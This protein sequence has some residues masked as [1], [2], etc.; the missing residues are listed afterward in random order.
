MAADAK[1]LLFDEPTSGLDFAHM[2]KVGALLKQL[3]TMGRTVLV[4]TH[5]PELIE[6][7]CDYLLCIKNG[8]VK[9]ME[10]IEQKSPNN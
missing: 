9:Y 2:E 3:A 1:L 5:D 7:S 8:R 6:L 10:R 4:V